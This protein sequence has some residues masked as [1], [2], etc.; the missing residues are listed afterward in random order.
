MTQALCEAISALS[1]H[2]LSEPKEEDAASKVEEATVVVDGEEE[3]AAEAKKA[4]EAAATRAAL[5]SK[6]SPAQV[7]RRL[8]VLP[9]LLHLLGRMVLDSSGSA[10]AAAKSN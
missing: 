8:E 10:G 7:K 6:L 1:P 9:G 5:L 4:E 3:A 2:M